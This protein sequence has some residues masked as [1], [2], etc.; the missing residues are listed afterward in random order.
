[1]HGDADARPRPFPDSLCWSCEH[2]REVAGA[3][4]T[5]ILCTTLAVKYPPQPVR[6]CGAH[7]HAKASPPGH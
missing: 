4:S 1:M 3:R 6:A 5:F 2:H 7:V